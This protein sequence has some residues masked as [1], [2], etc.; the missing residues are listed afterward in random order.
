MVVANCIPIIY[1]VFSRRSSW[2]TLSSVS[3]SPEEK[4]K[5]I[6]SK[7][8][9]WFSRFISASVY[10]NGM[11][12]SWIV[13]CK[14]AYGLLEKN[15]YVT[16]CTYYSIAWLNTDNTGIGINTELTYIRN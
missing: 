7:S 12:N 1:I 6:L 16:Y 14:A 10:L 2:T 11:V 3:W 5:Q 15:F 8:N 13:L 4:H 9:F